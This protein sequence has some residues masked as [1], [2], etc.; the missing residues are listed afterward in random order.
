MRSNSIHMRHAYCIFIHINWLLDVIFIQLYYF[1]Q[2]NQLL[3]TTGSKI[4]STEDISRRLK[5]DMQ[6]RLKLEQSNSLLYFFY[7]PCANK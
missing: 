1:E 2:I 4:K 6:S 7:P 5:I 3:L